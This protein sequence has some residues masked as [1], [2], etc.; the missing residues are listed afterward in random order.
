MIYS[1]SCSQ[2]KRLI[3]LYLS[4]EVI[5]SILLIKTCSP[6]NR[7]IEGLEKYF[8]I[9]KIFSQENVT[10]WKNLGGGTAGFLFPPQM[11]CQLL[12][13]ALQEDDGERHWKGSRFKPHG[14]DFW[15]PLIF[16]YVSA[17]STVSSE[18]AEQMG[19]TRGAHAVSESCGDTGPGHTGTCSPRRWI[20]R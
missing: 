17:S 15:V 2:T 5:R 7:S 16:L 9:H 20:N 13:R 14:S 10:S 11:N 18:V 19:R 12:M 3:K 8:Y 1:H 4:N 6:P